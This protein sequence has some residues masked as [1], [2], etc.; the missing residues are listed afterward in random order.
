[1]RHAVRLHPQASIAVQ[2]ADLLDIGG[3]R[4][5]A[6]EVFQRAVAGITPPVDWLC[7]LAEML[8]ADHQCDAALET[9]RQAVE[10]APENAAVRALLANARQLSA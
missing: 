7:R 6:I 9:Y 10:I 2:L 8:L 3:R 1:M 5:E 4:R